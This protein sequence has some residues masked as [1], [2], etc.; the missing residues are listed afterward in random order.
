METQ[1]SIIV[2]SLFFFCSSTYAQWLQTNLTGSR[3]NTI[4]VSN[5]NLFAGT[6]GNGIYIS[7]NNGLNWSGI[8]VGSAGSTFYTF[9]FSGSNVFAGAWGGGVFLQPTMA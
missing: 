1:F 5:N 2:A 6:N 4:L 7:T 3:V 9:A 8:N